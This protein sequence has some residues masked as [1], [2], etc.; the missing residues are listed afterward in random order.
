MT[1]PDYNGRLMASVHVSIL[2]EEALADGTCRNPDYPARAGHDGPCW[3]RRE[4]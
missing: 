1:G 3:P 2:I 4:A